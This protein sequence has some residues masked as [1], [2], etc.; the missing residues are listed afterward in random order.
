MSAE[1]CCRVHLASDARG[2]GQHKQPGRKA[3]GGLPGEPGSTLHHAAALARRQ[4]G[5]SSWQSWERGKEETFCCAQAG[6]GAAQRVPS[7]LSQAS[8][9]G[10]GRGAQDQELEAPPVVPVL[11]VGSQMSWP[12]PRASL[13]LL[14]GRRSA[15]GT[16][17]PGSCVEAPSGGFL[18][19][20]ASLCARRGAGWCS[21][22]AGGDRFVRP[23][24]GA[25]GAWL[26][27]DTP[28]FLPAC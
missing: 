10:G 13:G 25:A 27:G 22:R 12:W 11:L 26:C 4:L 2:S 24:L 14:Q 6:D 16:S 20:A 9:A 18:P 8:E 28:C 7:R 15:G 3:W 21:G 5:D 17:R 23:L 1:V 19:P